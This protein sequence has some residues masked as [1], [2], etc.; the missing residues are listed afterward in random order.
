M[1][2]ADDPKQNTVKTEK[3]GLLENVLSLRTSAHAGVA[4]TYFPNSPFLCSGCNYEQNV[5]RLYFARVAKKQLW[6]YNKEKQQGEPQ[7]EKEDLFDFGDCIGFW[8]DCLR[9]EKSS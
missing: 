6:W 4:A 5:S 1:L 8:N 9:K 2:S 3:K 7:Y